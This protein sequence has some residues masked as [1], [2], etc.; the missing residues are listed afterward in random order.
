MDPLIKSRKSWLYMYRYQGKPRRMT[1]GTYPEMGLADAHLAHAAARKTLQS[2]DDPGVVVV[3]QRQEE[4]DADTIR[5]LVENYLEKWARPRKRSAY[6]DER[7]LRKDVI[8]AW[9]HR[10][11]RSITR[12]EVID[13]LDGIVE[14]G[15]PIQ[16][17]RTLA[18]IRRMFR[19]ALSRDI[20]DAT[21]C[22]GIE[23]PS[24]ER[25]R[26][27]VLSTE[28]I[29][30]FWHGLDHAPMSEMVRLA[31]RLQ[32]VTAQR[33]GE[34]VAAAWD[35]FDLDERMWTIPG[36]RSK[37]GQTHRVPLS[38]MALSVIATIREKVGGPDILFPSARTG[39]PITPEAINHAL[40]KSLPAMD[41]EDMVPHDL[42]RTAA[43]NMTSLGIPRLVVAKILNHA[44]VGVTAVYDRHG[45]DAEKR[46]ALDV[47]GG[48]LT[49]IVSGH[50]ASS[51]VLPMRS[52]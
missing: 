32:L 37:N 49:E 40:L 19:W 36:H 33:K 15:A 47:W 13:L 3:K 10:K 46:R 39:K 41:I 28:E 31:L 51:N 21:P 7:I 42:R 24:G 44:E 22:A 25:K 17:N 11:A 1:L 38:D 20:L 45:Y 34:L 14:R 27:R 18:V 43:S 16:A 48:R 23:A 12:R 4:R 26:E 29:S 35:E 9:G 30:R 2:G 52:T 5:E 6:E 50:S 8:P